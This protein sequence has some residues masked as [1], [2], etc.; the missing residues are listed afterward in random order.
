MSFS[1]WSQEFRERKRT[2]R[3]ITLLMLGVI[4]PPVLWLASLEAAFAV[5]YPACWSG[6]RG[7][8]AAVAL[9][10]APAIALIAWLLHRTEPVR[11]TQ[12][13]EEPWAPW[14]A[15]LGLVT[16]ALLALVVVAMMAPIFVLDPCR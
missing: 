16:C 6:H 4:A 15:R 5:T 14:L 9:A 3:Q 11:H 8:L 13:A 1:T 7:W 10:P 12:E 2:P